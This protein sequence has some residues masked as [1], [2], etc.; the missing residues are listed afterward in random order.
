MKKS[1]LIT[2]VFFLAL[3]VVILSSCK[4]GWRL[5]STPESCA[6][7]HG[8]DNPWENIF[9]FDTNSVVDTADYRLIIKGVKRS[10]EFRDEAG[11]IDPSTLKVLGYVKMGNSFVYKVQTR[12]WWNQCETSTSFWSEKPKNARSEEQIKACITARLQWL[13]DKFASGQINDLP[14]VTDTFY[15]ADQGLQSG[16]M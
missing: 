10:L 6:N 11:A 14:S 4:I 1:V 2:I 12:K 5:K 16:W 7:L 13:A 8:P 3:A 9:N 15:V